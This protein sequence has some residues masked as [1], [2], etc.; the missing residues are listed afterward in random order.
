MKELKSVP[1]LKTLAKEASA[2]IQTAQGLKRNE[3]D[4]TFDPAAVAALFAVPE[5]GFAYAV[6]ADGKGAKV[7]QSQAVLLPA[8]DPASADAK[9]IAEQVEDRRRRTTCCHGL[10]CGAAERGR[11]HR[12]TKRSGD[13]SRARRRNNS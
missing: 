8:F 7:M 13:R 12:S 11:R 1:R 10:S 3:S 6:E 9:A 2:E 4:A 5:N